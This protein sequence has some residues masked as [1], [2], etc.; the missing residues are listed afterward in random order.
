MAVVAI[1]PPGSQRVPPVL[2]AHLDL[3]L[4]AAGISGATPVALPAALE[5]GTGV[6][7]ETVPA[8]KHGRFPTL[9]TSS[10]QGSIF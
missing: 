2:H 4:G 9:G 1:A 8:W 3:A 7:T 5:S 6:H 10:G